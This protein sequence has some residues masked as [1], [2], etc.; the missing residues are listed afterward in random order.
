[1]SADDRT[2]DLDRDRGHR[3][4]KRSVVKRR[5]PPGGMRAR[6][7][8][9]NILLDVTR[10]I[11]GTESLDEILEALVEMTSLAISCDRSSFFL[12]DPSTGEL[13]SRIAQ[14]VSRREIW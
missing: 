11:S 4:A 6:L 8:D 1:M 10:R 12:N 2:L 14:G 7:Q 13:Y 9:V 3:V 5:Q